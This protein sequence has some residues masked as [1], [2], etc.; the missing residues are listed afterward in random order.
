MMAV[1][2]HDLR[3]PRPVIDLS[4]NLIGRSDGLSERRQGSLTR[5]KSA[6]D[7]AI[8]LI[9]DLLDFSQTR[10]GRRL[11]VDLTDRASHAV[12]AESVEELRSVYPDSMF[13]HVFVGAGS[14]R[15]SADKIVQLVENLVSNAVA[16]GAKG[17]PII[18]K[19]EVGADM[20]SISVCNEG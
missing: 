12:V 16:Y 2:S 9:A 11:R 4:A 3:N 19:S 18:I 13:Q 8:R 6:T 10:V 17:R 20:V 5:L 1:V 15:V 7:R 14:S